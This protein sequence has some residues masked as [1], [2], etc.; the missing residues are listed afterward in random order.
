MGR[1]QP[2]KKKVIDEKTSRARHY[3]PLA[4]AAIQTLLGEFCECK[5]DGDVHVDEPVTE[6]T[7]R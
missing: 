5:M 7:R 6:P 2:L 4:E 3:A 1:R